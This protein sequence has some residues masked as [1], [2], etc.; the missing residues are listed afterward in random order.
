M[1]GKSQLNALIKQYRKPL[2]DVNFPTAA[3]FFIDSSILQYQI[4]F[5]FPALAA[6]VF[7]LQPGAPNVR[8]LAS[9]YSDRLLEL[10]GPFSHSFWFFEGIATKPVSPSRDRKRAKKLNKALRTIVSRN[11]DKVLASAL[12]R[13]T[14]WFIEL[15]ANEMRNRGHYV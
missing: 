2:L 14:P 5:K 4:N 6:Q 10:A 9:I 3:H 11:S 13:P 12:G 8:N 1:T 15:V 7:R